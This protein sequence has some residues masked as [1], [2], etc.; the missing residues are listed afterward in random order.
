VEAKKVILILGKL[1]PPY[2]GPSIA[3]E[4]LLNSGL[5][6]N[7]KLIHVNTK[8]NDDL[9]EI[10]KWSFRKIKNNF[11]I[12]NGMI[13]KIRMNKPDLV[14][15]PISQSTIGFLKDSVFIMIARFYK[16][17]TL[18]HLRGSNF[19]QWLNRTNFLV[20]WY[21]VKCLKSTQGVIVL[22]Q[23]LRYI[24]EEYFPKEKIF[25]SPNGG[26][27]NLPERI[28]QDN[29]KIRILYLGN[30]Q[31]SKGIQDVIDAAIIMQQTHA[32]KFELEIIGAWR[33][34]ELKSNC[35]K[36]AETSGLPVNFFPPESGKNKLQH[37]RNADIFVF[38]PREPEG[39]PWV[40]VEAMAAGLP[41][42][43]TDKGAIIESVIDGRNGYIV[44]SGNPKEI[45]FRMV[46][47]TDNKDLR[48]RMGRESRKRYEEAF[49]EEKMVSN[50]S[51]IFNSV[52]NS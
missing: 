31:A 48:E 22:G 25:V 52:I 8:I 46:E 15:I 12:W 21:S 32:G 49:T 47:L 33:N 34:E 23:N 43:S 10:G 6:E 29:E 5:K 27:Y 14:L 3:T 20:K 51:T 26:N 45:A 28:R 1:P 18:L 4:I 41:I 50:L 7:F 24:F 17:K 44:P 11:N 19:K 35:L 40:I 13:T 16:C 9:N 38:P 37:L 30:L 36:K 39:H 2:M 42:I